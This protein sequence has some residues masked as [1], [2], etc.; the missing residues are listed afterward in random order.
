MHARLNW[1]KAAPD[2]YKAMIALENAVTGSGLE[3]SLLEL[4]RIRSSQLNG[5]AFCLD[6]HTAD[7]RKR[8][9]SERRIYTL[10]AWRETP[11]FSERERAALA[12]TEALTQLAGHEVSEAL[13]DSV[14]AQFGDKEM[15]DLTL[16]VNAINSWNRIGV[17]FGLQPAG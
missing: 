6:M 10:S 3:P 9:E 5:C 12:W 11:F 17:G 8:G 1:A 4:I 15:V 2:A 16:A 13:Y 7:A 14:K